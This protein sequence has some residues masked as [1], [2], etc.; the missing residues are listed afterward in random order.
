M[1]DQQ[2]NCLVCYVEEIYGCMPRPPIGLA[3]AI[4]LYEIKITF[5]ALIMGG[6]FALQICNV[7]MNRWT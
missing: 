3:Q 6:E 1:C 2:S 7:T 4:K 5:A